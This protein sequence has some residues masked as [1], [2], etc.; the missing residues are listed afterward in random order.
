MVMFCCGLRSSLLRL[1]ACCDTPGLRSLYAGMPG[2]SFIGV[3]VQHCWAV[4]EGEPG[5]V[6]ELIVKNY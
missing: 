6:R 4:R 5:V 3:D 1:V 2:V